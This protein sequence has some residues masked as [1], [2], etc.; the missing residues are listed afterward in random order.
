MRKAWN[1]L[2]THKIALLV[3]LALC[4]AGSP[5]PARATTPLTTYNFGISSFVEDGANGLIYGT[6][7]GANEVVVINPATRAVTKT[8][9]VGSTPGSLCVSPDGSTVYVANGGSTTLS[10]ISTSTNTVSSTINLGSGNTPQSVQTGTNGRLWVY[11]PSQIQQF[12][13]S[14]NS[15]G[16]AL[17]SNAS[18]GFVLYSGGKIVTS[19]GGSTLYYAGQSTSPSYLYKWDVSG[20]TG[21]GELGIASGGN[22]IDLAVSPNGNLVL[23]QANV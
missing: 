8:L 3:M 9:T 10:V 15:T 6:V 17:A 12:D 23:K 20:A 16:P 19:N 5:K 4:V 22:G 7:P 13:T 21:V 14:G 1:T 2:R 11:T 18:T